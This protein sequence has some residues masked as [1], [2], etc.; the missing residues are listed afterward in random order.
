MLTPRPTQPTETPEEAMLASF[1]RM[2]TCPMCHGQRTTTRVAGDGVGVISMCK[3]C[4][5]AGV[6][7]EFLANQLASLSRD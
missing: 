2:T 1:D 3:T 5:G 7:T 4:R 6:C